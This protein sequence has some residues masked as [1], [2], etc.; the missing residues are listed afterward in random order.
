MPRSGRGGV[1]GDLWAGWDAI[2]SA[3][4]YL[5]D[6]AIV[7]VN[8]NPKGTRKEAY[9]LAAAVAF[10]LVRRYDHTQYLGPPPSIIKLEYDAAGNTV[11]M[12]LR[13]KTNLA[14]AAAAGLR[15]TV[16]KL[17]IINGPP[18]EIV[19]ERWNYTGVLAAQIDTGG[20]LSLVID[21]IPGARETLGI[22]VPVPAPKLR[23]TGRPIL[24][25]NPTCAQPDPTKPATETVFSPN[26][27]PVGDSR[28]RG[29]MYN[30][31]YAALTTPQG[32]GLKEFPAPTVANQYIGG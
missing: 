26:P 17:A 20:P 3:L 7:T 23:F 32:A 15:D 1:F 6:E 12:S 8:V 4:P 30:L 19:G 28:T 14:T 27:R 13:Y 25:R 31:V 10:S 29:T 11:R 2:Q 9:F 5:E 21:R 18:E 22:K 24:T 16:G